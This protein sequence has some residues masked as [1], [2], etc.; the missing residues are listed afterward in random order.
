MAT[1]RKSDLGSRLKE[2][3]ERRGVSLRQIANDTKISMTVLEALERN[4]I[5]RLP[6]GI[7]SRSF[8]RSYA[9]EV[10]L[11]VEEAVEDFIKQFPLDSVTVGHAPSHGS[12]EMDSFESDRR[13]ASAVL[14]ML[15]LSVPI[16]GVILYFG[17]RTPA[18][19]DTA[20]AA[21]TA[22]VA[23]KP[24]TSDDGV[25]ASPLRLEIVARRAFGLS[26]AIDGAAASE[27]TLAAGD[28]RAFDI[29]TEATITSSDAGAFEWTINGRPGRPAGPAGTPATLR[30]TTANY[31]GFLGSR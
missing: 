24:E 10:G 20:A 23:A 22:A 6:G 25:P 19:R 9:T 31:E 16:A 11:N 15:G 2:A 27:V 1:E 17:L 3:R 14:W 21:P 12:D 7:F 4:D 28:R 29:K 18:A 30:L 13:V 26:I 5:S 8:V